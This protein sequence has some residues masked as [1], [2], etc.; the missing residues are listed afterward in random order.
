VYNEHQRTVSKA[1]IIKS[2]FVFY[3]S[4]EHHT[5]HFNKINSGK[6]IDNFWLGLKVSLDDSR[7]VTL[8]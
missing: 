1:I 3:M 5:P 8:L 7:S 4:A 2:W 6:K